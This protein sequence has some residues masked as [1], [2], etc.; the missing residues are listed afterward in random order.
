MTPLPRRVT[1]VTNGNSF[2][3]LGLEPL[4]REAGRRWD[5]QVLVT[6]GLRK[7]SGNRAAEVLALAR[8]WGWRYFGYKATTYLL[9][10][11]V[12]ALR[13]RPTDVRSLCAELGLPVTVVRN[14]NHEPTL[15]Q[16]GEFAPD[17]LVSYS[18]PYRIR[19]ALLGTPRVGSLNV[20]SSL[21]PAYAGVC[22]Y[23]HVLA[24]GVA[25][26]GV[27]VHEMV[28]EFDAGRVV[29]QARV[30]IAGRTSTFALFTA[31]CRLAGEL[32]LSAVDRCLAAGEIVGCPQDLTQRSY[33]GEPTAHDVAEL[34][35]RGH[36]LM[37]AAD[38]RDAL[39]AATPS[40]RR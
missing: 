8:R 13:R 31:Q 16:V 18:C 5:V 17:L 28:E 7:H 6:T 4:L 29:E 12:T 35:R 21:L 33:R 10:S 3:M 39:A 34:R 36:R 26:T 1:V 24:D 9:P 23:V 40:D 14:V 20:H 27:T 11:A 2:A 19:S 38:V 32:L 37:R 15:S 22:T 25:E 30:P